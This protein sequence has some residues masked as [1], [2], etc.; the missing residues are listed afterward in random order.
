MAN[1]KKRLSATYI[2]VFVIYY[3]VQAI[4]LFVKVFEINLNLDKLIYFA[5]S[6]LICSLIPMMFYGQTIGKF[7]L[8]IRIISFRKQN[9]IM[10]IFFRET[11]G[12]FIIFPIIIIAF[13]LTYFDKKKGPT[14]EQVTGCKIINL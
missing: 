10:S 7:C 3:F 4:R 13:F 14:F 8:K 2:D 9:R 6:Y 11:V 12:K 1:W 5:F